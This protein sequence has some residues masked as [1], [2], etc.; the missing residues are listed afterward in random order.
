LPQLTG[1]KRKRR[2]KGDDEDEGF[3]PGF[4]PG[5]QSEK[6]ASGGWV[7]AAPKQDSVRSWM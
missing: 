5:G 4:N 3:A 6:P 1:G 7:G 2:K